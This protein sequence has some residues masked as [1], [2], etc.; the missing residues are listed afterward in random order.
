MHLSCNFGLEYEGR[1]LIVGMDMSEGQPMLPELREALY[2]AY[3]IKD[4]VTAGAPSFFIMR[5]F[6]GGDGHCKDIKSL[7]GFSVEVRKALL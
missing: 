4:S 6:R 3:S 5:M 1:I 2:F 7:V